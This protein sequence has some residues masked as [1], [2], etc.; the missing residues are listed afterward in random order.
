MTLH[1]L[2][3]CLLSGMTEGRVAEIVRKGNGFDQ[4]FIQA[5]A[6]RHELMRG[7]ARQRRNVLFIPQANLAQHI[8]GRVDV[9]LLGADHRPAALE[10]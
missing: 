2:I 5:Q 1:A 4:I 7:G 6:A 3:Q 10:S 9:A 8:A